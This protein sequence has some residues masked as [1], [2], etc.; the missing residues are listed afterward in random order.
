MDYMFI[1]RGGK[2]YEGFSR[3]ERLIGKENLEKAFKEAKGYN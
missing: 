2:M 1:I 3:E